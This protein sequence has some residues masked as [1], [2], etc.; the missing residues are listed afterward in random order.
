VLGISTAMR[1]GDTGQR[2]PFHIVERRNAASGL[3]GTSLQGY[4]VVG[5]RGLQQ[6]RAHY[7]SFETEVLQMA[8]E[9]ADGEAK[10]VREVRGETNLLTEL[11]T[12]VELTIAR[13]VEDREGCSIHITLQIV[14]DLAITGH[15]G[16]HAEICA[17]L[18]LEDSTAVLQQV[19]RRAIMVD[20][21][22]V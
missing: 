9:A 12:V 1:Q 13:E 15:R 2:L 22:R 11:L 18:G 17:I 8:V 5:V 19:I 10:P 6:C 20:L 4:N 21:V 7:A 16:E 14:G 3:A